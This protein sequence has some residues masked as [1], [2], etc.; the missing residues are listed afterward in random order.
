WTATL[1]FQDGD[2]SVEVTATIED[3]AGNTR[4][5]TRTFEKDTTNPELVI[6]SPVAGS[7]V[8]DSTKAAFTV[9]G[10]CS[11]PGINNVVITG[12]ASKTV[13]CENDNTWSADLDFSAAS[14][15]VVSI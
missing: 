9:S 7:Y 2:E 6:T 13:N 4:V 10:T 1:A 12:A 3:E 11:D 15:G 14:D 5:A 8:N